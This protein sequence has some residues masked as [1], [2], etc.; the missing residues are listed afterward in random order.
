MND[1]ACICRGNW[2]LIVA[3]CEHLIGCQFRDAHNGDEY[4]FFGLVHADDDYYYGMWREGKLKLLSCVSDIGGN[5][6]DLVGE[7]PPS[8]YTN[9]EIERLREDAHEFYSKLY[10][11]LL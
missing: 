8:R 5:G 6:F 7:E 2:R 4:T 3:E 9:E 11:D 1:P 10:S